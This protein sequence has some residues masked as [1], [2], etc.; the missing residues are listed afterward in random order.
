MKEA[1]IKI[2]FKDKFDP[3]RSETMMV[4]CTT[5]ISL[6]AETFANMMNKGWTRKKIIEK[7]MVDSLYDHIQLMFSKRCDCSTVHVQS[8][9]FI[10]VGMIGALNERL[11]KMTSMKIYSFLNMKEFD[12]KDNEWELQILDINQHMNLHLE[13][14]PDIK[15]SVE[16]PG[17]VYINRDPEFGVKIWNS[18][19]IEKVERTAWETDNIF[20]IFN[21]GERTINDIIED[22][23]DENYIKFENGS[24]LFENI[25]NYDKY[26]ILFLETDYAVVPTTIINLIHVCEMEIGR[27]PSVTNMNHNTF[28][29]F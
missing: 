18:K 7:H 12:G 1:T 9:E 24:D 6:S 26:T 22:I 15:H 8:E 17:Y 16:N 23:K 21:H 27:T 11:L 29:M 14:D 10:F 2:I 5:G 20:V 28:L 19:P 25:K 4:S 13:T 3:P